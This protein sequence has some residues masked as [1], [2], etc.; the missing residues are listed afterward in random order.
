[1]RQ[2]LLTLGLNYR[3]TPLEVRERLAFGEEEVVAALNRLRLATSI[4]E[5]ALIST[6]NRVELIAVAPDSERAAEELAGFLVVDRGVELASF[7]D[8]LYRYDAREAARH[9]FRVGASLDSMVVGEPQIL[10]QLKQAYAWA[11][12]AGT[13]G[14]V[15][16]RAF[17]RAFSVAKRVR[18][19]TLIGRGSVSVSAA[20]VGLAR[21][22][23][24]TMQDKKVLLLGAGEMAELTA[25][26]LSRLGIESL[27]IA[28]RSFDRAIAL[29]RRLGGTAVPYDA[30][31]PY[32]K[33]A[34]VVIG[35]LA[36]MHPV[37]LTDDLAPLLKER[38]YRPMFLIDLGVPRNFHPEL[39][40]LDNVYLYNIDD[41]STAVRDN[42]E[43]REREAQ[44]AELIVEVELEAFW[45]WLSGL[46]LVPAIKDIR[47]NVERLRADELERHRAWL[48][49]LSAEERMQVERLT[50]R[51]I[52]KIL[53][54]VLS[55]LRAAGGHDATRAAELA[56]QLLGGDYSAD[57]TAALAPVD[58]PDDEQD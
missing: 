42:Q 26:Q 6:C 33:L 48:S 53:H 25:R 7:R 19:R 44:K 47:N 22:I 1:M 43:E 13:V 50:R 24:D 17:H 31:K 23:F 52:N 20:A 5:V 51:L 41:L 55:Q 16:H 14:V 3:T 21:Q 29:A 32:L 35:S 30:Y 57:V 4:D 28:S 46:E 12:E 49:T 39:N 56:R 8:A 10:G 58:E 40:N 37:L 54:Q 11:A 18:E 2:A 34:D 38:K 36:T 27:M 9:L 45:R 15:L